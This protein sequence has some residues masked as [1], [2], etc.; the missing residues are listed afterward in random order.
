MG[1]K[2]R[3]FFVAIVGFFA[4]SVPTR[5]QQPVLLQ[6]RPHVGDTLRVRLDQEV[7]MTGMPAG[8][9]TQSSALRGRPKNAPTNCSD[10]RS[11]TT[12]MEVYSRAI[13]RKSSRDATDLLAITDSV[14]TSPG[15]G[16]ARLK[17][18]IPRNPVEIRI[19]S[20]GS[21]ELGAGQA[22][23]EVREMFGQMP[24]TLSRKPLAIGEKWIHEMK[25]P[26][27]EEPGATGLVRTT[28]QLDS[29]GKGGNVAYIS[30][31]GVLSHDHSD[32]SNSDTSGSLTGT[33]QL[34][35]RLAWITDTHATID[36]WSLVRNSA[37]GKPMDVHTRVVQTLKVTA[38]R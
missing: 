13:V 30:M 25:V 19:T 12:T 24:A 35:R 1:S 20:D 18:P 6:I 16:H 34:D 7:A 38:S 21:V 26:L 33:M 32:G 17:Q 27:P 22:T 10:V 37:S 9:G 4:A 29:L 3:S 5:A 36:V 31:R 8:C 2:L 11:M 15:P 28:L 14:M 23:D